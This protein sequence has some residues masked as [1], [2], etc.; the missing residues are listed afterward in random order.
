MT[1]NQVVLYANG[2]VYKGFFVCPVERYCI[3]GVKFFGYSPCVFDPLIW[4]AFGVM[5]NYIYPTMAEADLHSKEMVDDMIPDYLQDDLGF[6]L[7]KI[8]AGMKSES[9][10]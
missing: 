2:E 4:S 10:M 5:E 3:D 9:S 6:L 1:H 7:E 8:P